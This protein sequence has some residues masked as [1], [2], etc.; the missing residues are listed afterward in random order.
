MSTAAASSHC[1][2]PS[3]TLLLLS[4]L[5]SALLHEYVWQQLLTKLPNFFG[6]LHLLPLGH[7]HTHLHTDTHTE[8]SVS[9]HKEVAGLSGAQA[10]P[11]CTQPDNQVL[12]CAKT[13][14]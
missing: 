11:F 12:Q 5:L 10:T 3:Q 14:Q 2:Q 8:G 9:Q 7:Q 6:C 4:A 13:S 1:H